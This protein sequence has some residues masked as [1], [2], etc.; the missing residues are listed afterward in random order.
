MT[1]VISH[2]HFVYV[3]FVSVLVSQTFDRKIFLRLSFPGTRC[4]SAG[5][6]NV[7]AIRK[8]LRITADV[9]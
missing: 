5:L 7:Y 2:S 8:S 1:I 9:E 4:Y 3:T 6:T